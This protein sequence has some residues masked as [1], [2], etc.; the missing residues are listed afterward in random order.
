MVDLFDHI[1]RSVF[2]T[3]PQLPQDEVEKVFREMDS[4]L[5]SSMLLLCRSPLV[6]DA[7]AELTAD[8][9]GSLSHGRG[10]YARG[11]VIKRVPKENKEARL[12]NLKT[13]WHVDPGLIFR[14]R[15]KPDDDALSFIASSMDYYKAWVTQTDV[16]AA[17]AKVRLSRASIESIFDAFFRIADSYDEWSSHLAKMQ[18]SLLRSED[19]QRSA[20]LLE[21]I[22]LC[23]EEMHQIEHELGFSD[24]LWGVLRELKQSWARYKKLRDK[25]Y[26]PYLRVVFNES[27]KRARTEIQ[28]LE[29]FQNGAIG[30]M[31][32]VSNYNP[33]RGVFSSYAQLWATQG[34]LLKLKDEAN[35]IKLPAAVWQTA[36]KLNA[37]AQQEAAKSSD[38]NFDLETVAKAA[39]I[40][41]KRAEKIYERI[42]ST[43]MLSIDFRV[44]D[45]S[46]SQSLHETL[47]AQK[48]DEIPDIVNFLS[49]LPERQQWLLLLNYGVFDSLPGTIP[50]EPVALAKERLRQNI[51]LALNSVNGEYSENGGH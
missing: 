10:I 38:G 22:S 6:M 30:L 51:A 7:I 17:V 50:N 43:Q 35:H 15:N 16:E 19:L 18:V 23:N 31:I 36:N 11:A 40:D 25:V 34:I 44:N 28:T 49:Q 32:A 41:S 5:D 29:N 48:S 8:V 14:Y 26:I 2:R 13:L 33:I 46:E 42:R 1:W 3:A 27:R 12:N 24:E 39:G 9:V 37:I 20:K 21:Q 47:E 4:I 45:D